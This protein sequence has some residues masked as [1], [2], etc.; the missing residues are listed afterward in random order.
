[1]RDNQTERT[2][3]RGRERERERVTVMK[4]VKAIM[5]SETKQ[6]A[7]IKMCSTSDVQVV[8]WGIFPH[9]GMEGRKAR[10]P[11]PPSP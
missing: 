9:Y 6:C 8:L 3:D 1:M 4:T 11:R 2:R 7:V 10:K 5:T